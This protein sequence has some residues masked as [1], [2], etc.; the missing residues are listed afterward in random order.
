M[1]KAPPAGYSPE[2]DPERSA[3]IPEAARQAP[4]GPASPLGI[5]ASGWRATVA[6]TIGEIREDRITITAAG[7]AFYWFLA[8]FPLLFAGIALLAIADASPSFVDGSSRRSERPSRATPP[9]S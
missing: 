2:M 8:V 4:G 9:R 6:R 5:P 3:P 1:D 7:V